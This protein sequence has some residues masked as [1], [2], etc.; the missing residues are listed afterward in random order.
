MG[1]Q[2]NESDFRTVYSQMESAHSNIEGAKASLGD[3]SSDSRAMK[4]FKQ[5]VEELE[6]LKNEYAAL[7]KKDM[8][9]VNQA[10]GNIMDLDTQQCS[11]LSGGGSSAGGDSR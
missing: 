11:G 4:A 5:R 8:G 6:K 2:V 3:V 9:A 10:V 1:I 7:F